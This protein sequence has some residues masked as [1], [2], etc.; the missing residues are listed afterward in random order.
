MGPY[1]LG[2]VSGASLC[3]PNSLSEV[4]GSRPPAGRTTSKTHDILRRVWRTMR[5]YLLILCLS[6]PLFATKA[7]DLPACPANPERPK[8]DWLVS[9]TAS[10]AILC[11]NAH[12]NE[13]AMSNGL[14][15]RAWRLEP[16]AAS[17]AFD[18]L[19]TG[20]ALLRGVKP[21]AAVTLDGHPYNIGGLARPAGLCLSSLRMAR[22]D[23]SRPRGLPV[24]R[25]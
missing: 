2:P 14:I 22:P 24:Y 11:R 10:H 6:L 25:F 1:R 12:P 20:A 18:N 16:D 17:V 19:S 4:P 5:R 8:Y 9:G 21:E 7:D 13:I 23:D 15:R 3:G